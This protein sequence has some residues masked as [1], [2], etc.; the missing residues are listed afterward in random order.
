MADSMAS[1]I[2]YIVQPSVKV[3]GEKGVYNIR[4]GDQHKNQ[5]IYYCDP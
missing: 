5:N 3:K 2:Q 1:T 4:K